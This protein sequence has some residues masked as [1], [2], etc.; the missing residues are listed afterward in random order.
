MN[1]N[2]DKGLSRSS[3][4]APLSSLYCNLKLRITGDLKSKDLEN[5]YNCNL[6]NQCHLAGVNQSAR[7]MS[8]KKDIIAWHVAEIKENINKSGNSYGIEQEKGDD[9]IANTETLLFKGCTPT[10]KTPEI[11]RAAENLLKAEKIQYSNLD[12]ETCCGNILFNLGDVNAGEEAVR[13]N[14]DKFKQRGVKRIITLCPGCYNAFNKYYRGYD[15]FNPE[16][17]L[18]VDLISEIT[19]E[20]EGL[21]IQDPCHAREKGQVVRGILPNSRNK[22]NSPCCGAGAGVLA[23]NPSMATSKAMKAFDDK[24]ITV[25]YCP[26][27]YLN[28]SRVKPEK[29]KDLYRLIDENRTLSPEISTY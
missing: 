2:S 24:E 15:G 29:V 13:K 22:N 1:E 26:L 10:H 11:L 17:I 14:M 19:F 5:L 12:N 6:C 9:G 18:L 8:V 23:H 28:L 3:D 27:C 25:T 4:C 21:T 16:I 20:G 7:E